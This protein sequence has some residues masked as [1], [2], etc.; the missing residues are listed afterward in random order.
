[1]SESRKGKSDPGASIGAGPRSSK[2]SGSSQMCA[3]CGREFQPRY[4]HEQYCGKECRSVARRARNRQWMHGQHHKQAL[5]V[6]EEELERLRKPQFRLEALAYGQDKLCVC[7]GCGQVAV[8]LSRHVSACPTDPL[9]ADTYREKWGYDRSNALMAASESAKRRASRQSE[10]FQRAFA[11]K[12]APSFAAKRSQQAGDREREGKPGRRRMRL[13]SRLRRTG[14]SLP[15]RP[16]KQKVSDAV[17]LEIL[18]RDLPVADGARRAQLSVTAF[19]RRAKRLGWDANGVKA[20]RRIVNRYIFMLRGWL[21]GQRKIPSFDQILEWHAEGIRGDS[22]NA[23]IGFTPY[24]PHLKPIL[25]AEPD[26]LRKLS[27]P[28]PVMDKT[29]HGATLYLGNAAITL[30]AKVF[31]RSRAELRGRG[32]LASREKASFATGRAVEECVPTFEQAFELVRSLPRGHRRN[33][34]K[35]RAL[36]ERSG[37][38][39]EQ[40]ESV[41]MTDRPSAAARHF[42]AGK[43]NK[44]TDTVA[45]DHRLYLKAAGKPTRN[46]F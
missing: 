7:L 5:H 8:N 20:R 30:S 24:L 38:A 21:W 37:F 1:M 19:Y 27:E 41:L 39:P 28:Q 42:I 40:I 4:P 6:T 25:K 36:L 26:L 10:A 18:A 22:R 43:K 2:S 34:A 16:G 17:I 46:Q 45:N 44:Q 9:S 12:I 13:E 33:R 35:V 15:P 31:A 11:E 14:R 32:R 3:E 29:T 23:F